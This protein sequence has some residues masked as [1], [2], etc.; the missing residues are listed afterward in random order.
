MPTILFRLLPAILLQA[1]LLACNGQ[2][3]HVEKLVVYKNGRIWTGDGTQAMVST[4]AV[5][6]GRIVYAGNNPDSLRADSVVDLDGKMVVPGFIDNHTHFLSGGYQLNAVDL[7]KAGTKEEFITILKA[8]ISS[9]PGDTWIQGG[10]WD[11]EAWGGEL[12]RKEWIDSITGDRPV[13]V[14]RYDG[15]MALANSAALKRGRI[16][17]N[18][19]SPDGGDIQR[20]PQTGEP[21]G[22]L[23]D[24]AMGFIY[25]RIPDPS[26]EELESLLQRAIAHAQMNGVTQVHD[27]GSYG[28]WIDL[29]TYR[30]AYA[31]KDLGLRIYS[32]VPLATWQKLSDFI[33]QNGRGDEMLR[34]GALK[35]FVDGSLGS[36]TAW[37]YAPYLDD[38]TTSGLLVNDTGKLRTWIL[39]ADA[40]GLQVGVHAIGDRANDWLLDVYEEAISRKGNNSSRFRI[41]HAQHLSEKA[42]TRFAP[43]NVIPCVQPYHAIDDGRWAA[44]RLDDERLKRTYAFRSLWQAHARLSMGSDWTV[45]PLSPLEGIYAA[46]TRRTLDEKNPEGWYPEQKVT[47]EQALTCY[48]ANNAYAGFQEDILGRLRP[49]MLADFVV[50]SE[51]LFSIP[52]EKIRDVK[53]IATYVGGKKVYGRED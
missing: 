10:D 6:S 28:G 5:Q 24:D 38:P 52:A 11:H 46:V 4:I 26:E 36:T 21:T 27:M 19:K 49:G 45:A 8:Y 44:K 20:D 13:F 50:L 17:R 1:L 43:L 51:D 22:I 7:R 2:T 30:R 33:K 41:E 3:R 47:V 18:T 53:V 34:W 42:I 32:F 31:K 23:R 29:E 48:G 15:H 39:D 37:F 35:G 12:P 16:D 40:A 25:A 14:S 9:H